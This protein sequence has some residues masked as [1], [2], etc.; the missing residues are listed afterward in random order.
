MVGLGQSRQRKPVSI[1]RFQARR[2]SPEMPAGHGRRSRSALFLRAA[3]VV[4]GG[5][6]RPGASHD[7][8]PDG[9]VRHGVHQGAVEFFEHDAALGVEDFR[10]VHGQGQHRTVLCEFEGLV[11]HAFPFS[12]CVDSRHAEAAPHGCGRAIVVGPSRRNKPPRVAS[13][14]PFFSLSHPA[15]PLDLATDCGYTAHPAGQ[16]QH[17][18]NRRAATRRHSKPASQK[19]PD[20]QNSNPASQKRRM[21]G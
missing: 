3:D 11:S 1:Y 16:F 15:A 8:H 21:R 4:P 19:A 10:T 14:A 17:I 7:D 20:C 18:L 9:V 5:K 2:Y 12:R 6:M 13:W